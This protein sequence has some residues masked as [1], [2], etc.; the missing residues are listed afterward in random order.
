MEPPEMAPPEG[1]RSRMAAARIDRGDSA[2]M[3][4]AP[5]QPR[6][7][8]RELA[9]NEAA[10]PPADPAGDPRRSGTIHPSPR[11]ARARRP[12]RETF[13][14]TPSNRNRISAMLSA[15]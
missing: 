9:S 3:K 4:G 11:A 8:E 2:A 10:R 6:A 15:R 12:S 13:P 5:A 14:Q 7:S 1:E